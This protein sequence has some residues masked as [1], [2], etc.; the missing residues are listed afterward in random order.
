MLM[1]HYFPY[2]TMQNSNSVPAF[3]VWR[4]VF[5]VAYLSISICPCTPLCCSVSMSVCPAVSAERPA[6]TLCSALSPSDSLDLCQE[7]MIVFESCRDV[8]RG[9]SPARGR[10][11]S[12]PAP[13]WKVRGNMASQSAPPIGLP[14]F[15]EEMDGSL[16]SRHRCRIHSPLKGTIF[17]AP[18]P[19]DI[20]MSLIVEGTRVRN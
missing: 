2:V 19:Y 5:Y 16:F 1:A 10:V 18:V 3:S 12:K 14:H 9:R 15:C 11:S 13:S 6:P 20:L 7:R 17:T 4:S 8:R